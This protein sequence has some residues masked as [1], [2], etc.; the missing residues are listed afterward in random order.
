MYLYAYH[1]CTLT[2]GS[3]Y[4]YGPIGVTEIDR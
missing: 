2:L 3:F 1:T 4:M